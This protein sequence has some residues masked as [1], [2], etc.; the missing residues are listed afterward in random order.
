MVLADKTPEGRLQPQLLRQ[1]QHSKAVGRNADLFPLVPPH[2]RGQTSWLV[3]APGALYNHYLYLLKAMVRPVASQP[4]VTDV[5]DV[6]T[7]ASD[8]LREQRP[9]SYTTHVTLGTYMVHLG[10]RQ[11]LR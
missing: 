5:V 7:A 10:A 9:I 8:A 4:R 11:F 1:A 6:G 3:R 2:S